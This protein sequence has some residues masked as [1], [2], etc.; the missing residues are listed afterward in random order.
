[1]TEILTFGRLK[2]VL[3]KTLVAFQHKKGIIIDLRFNGGGWDRAAYKIASRFVS[4]KQMGH[5]QKKRIKGTRIKGTNEYGKL[6][7]F[8][9]MPKGKNQFTKPIVILT[10]DFTASASEF[11]LLAMK[12]FPYVTIVGDTTEG[13]F[14]EMHEFQLPNKWDVSLSHQH[15]FS[16]EMINYEGIG[17]EPDIVVLNSREDLETDIDPVITK[18]IA[19]LKKE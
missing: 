6:K 19:L 12:D 16:K 10:S 14:S 4:Q 3:N 18:A 7:S 15:F 8:S 5:L 1:M 2:K 13:I 9:V 11:F 17:I